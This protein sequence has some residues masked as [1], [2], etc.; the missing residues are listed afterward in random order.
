MD[1]RVELKVVA[2]NPEIYRYYG[3]LIECS[4]VLDEKEKCTKVAR[5][6]TQ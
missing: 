3:P 2:K 1:N 4:A 6:R 5:Y